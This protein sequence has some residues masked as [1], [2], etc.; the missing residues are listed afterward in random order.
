V[1]WRAEKRHYI[2]QGASMEPDHAILRAYLLGE[3][4][5]A[6]RQNIEE[7]YFKH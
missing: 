1:K 5:P 3:L 2:L 4:S 6:D 7:L